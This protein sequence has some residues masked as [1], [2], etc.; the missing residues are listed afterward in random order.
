MSRRSRRIRLIGIDKDMHERERP[1]DRTHADDAADPR[2][3]IQCPHQTWPTQALV[4][5]VTVLPRCRNA[6]PLVLRTAIAGVSLV[7]PHVL[8]HELMGI[9]GS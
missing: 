9:Q 4:P 7:P 6:S 8:L 1:H 2:R 5:A 3:R